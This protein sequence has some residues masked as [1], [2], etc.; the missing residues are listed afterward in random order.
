M[1]WSGMASIP[2]QAIHHNHRKLYVTIVM[3]ASIP[4]QAIHHKF[5]NKPT[6]ADPGLVSWESIPDKAIPGASIP[7]LAIHLKFSDPISYLG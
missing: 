3:E 6:G 1:A 7:D 4:D 5:E 2:D